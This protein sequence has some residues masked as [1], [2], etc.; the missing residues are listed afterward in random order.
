MKHPSRL[1]FFLLA[2]YILLARSSWGQTV[3]PTTSSNLQATS[4]GQAGSAAPLP[5]GVPAY[6]TFVGG[7]QGV[8]FTLD[9]TVG[10]ATLRLASTNLVI[11]DSRFAYMTAGEAS[12]SLQRTNLTLRNVVFEYNNNTAAGAILGNNSALIVQDSTFTGNAAFQTGA[13][14]LLGRSTFVASEVAFRSNSG[15]EGGAIGTSGG[16]TTLVARQSD[17]INNTATNG[18]ALFV[19]NCTSAFIYSSRFVNNSAANNGGGISQD[20][21]GGAISGSMFTG[22]RAQT[23]AGAYVTTASSFNVSDSTFQNNSVPSGAAGL[24]LNAVQGSIDNCLFTQNRGEKGGG[25]FQD[26]CTMPI[27]NSIFSA[28]SVINLG[29][30]VTRSAGSGDISN[31]TFTRNSAA[32]LGGAIFEQQ[33]VQSDIVACTFIGNTAPSGADITTRNS[34]ATLVDPNNTGLTVDSVYN[35]QDNLDT[36]VTKDLKTGRRQEFEKSWRQ[37]FNRNGAPPHARERWNPTGP[38]QRFQPRSP[39]I[40]SEPVTDVWFKRGDVVTGKIVWANEKGARVSLLKEPRIL[41]YMPAKQGPYLTRSSFEQVGKWSEVHEGTGPCLPVGLIRDFLIMNV[42]LDMSYE[43]KGPLLSAQ[44]LDLDTLWARAVQMVEVCYEDK[45]N[46][47]LKI[48]QTNQGGLIGMLESLQAFIPYSH[49]PKDRD[50]W[51]SDEELAATYTGKVVEATITEVKQD[52]RKVVMSMTIAEHNKAVRGIKLGSLVWGEVRKIND[53][54]C[55]V[56]LCGTKISGL[57]HISNISR[58]R[59]ERVEDCFQEG[60]RIRALVVGMDDGY[61]RISLSTAELEEHEGDMIVNAVGV[62]EN[63]EKQ[64][65]DYNQRL[66]A[67]NADDYNND[68]YDGDYM[69]NGRLGAGPT[70]TLDWA[71]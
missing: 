28:N 8:N 22:N 5:A 20:G 45:E 15:S 52:F 11:M 12:L 29:G 3:P 19:L 43:S 2:T 58:A 68:N 56:G 47:Q 16:N 54:G 50:Q 17:F 55:F 30:A 66:A 41:G 51:F 24:Q 14:R 60:D 44:A 13:I 25:V 53:F 69:N 46:F 26:G 63:A 4:A 65:E 61:A 33:M 32:V 36:G 37:P 7:F 1:A 59:V 31:C 9:E 71:S 10:G 62:F 67:M 70:D 42:P 6:A 40:A 38:P 18:G 57:L 34:D 23:G 39:P 21:C 48:E 35:Y 49:V 27:T 64:A